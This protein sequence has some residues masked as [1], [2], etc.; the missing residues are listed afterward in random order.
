MAYG[1]GVMYVSEQLKWEE[2]RFRCSLSFFF[3][4]DKY[5]PPPLG[6]WVEEGGE[7]YIYIYTHA[8]LRREENIREEVVARQVGHGQ[9]SSSSSSGGA[10]VSPLS[11]ARE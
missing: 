5:L 6:V 10:T 8:A 3:R 2:L 1:D 9:K 4:D 11:S 7:V